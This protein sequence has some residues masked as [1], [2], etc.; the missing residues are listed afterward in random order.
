MEELPTCSFSG[1][2][3]GIENVNEKSNCKEGMKFEG[4]L[5]QLQHNVTRVAVEPILS[6]ECLL[7]C[8]IPT[9]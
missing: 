3:I 4:I 6:L 7:Q 8:Y 9:P 2:Q 1:R 5:I